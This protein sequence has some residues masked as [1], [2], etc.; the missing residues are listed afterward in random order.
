MWL[1]VSEV[2]GK[3]AFVMANI[4]LARRL[5]VVDFGLFTLAQ[6][7]TFFFWLAADLGISLYGIREIARAKENAEAVINPLFTL[8][9]SAGV[10]AFCCYIVAVFATV[11]TPHA[12][13]TFVAAGVYLIT[14]AFNIDWVFKGLEKFKWT[15]IGNAISSLVFLLGVVVIVQDAGDT[16]MASILWA[17][18]Y[19]GGAT[20]LL[21]S[22]HREGV[23]IRPVFN[24]R[25]WIG[26]LKESLHFTIS[27]V[28]SLAGAYLPIA[29][30]GYYSGTYEVGIYSAPYR[31]VATVV[32]AGFLIP[33]AFY[34]VLAESFRKNRPLFNEAQQRLKLIMLSLGIIASFGGTLFARQ[35]LDLIYGESYVASLAVFQIIVWWIFLSYIRVSLG[36]VL[37]A[38]GFH[39]RQNLGV[40]AGAIAIAAASMVLIPVG[41]ASGA[42]N[43]LVVGECFTVIVFLLQSWRVFGTPTITEMRGHAA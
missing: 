29:F 2:L 30:L 14:Y 36:S 38:A 4:I 15:A 5:G 18:S 39:R 41:G 31:L 22:I 25:V 34:P 40:F 12:R 10:V 8:R 24:Y 27:G 33:T 1:L 35:I 19:A 16:I 42:A 3:G 32:T 17:V 9:I 20:F 23:R 7:Q 11:S 37:L 21:L 43:A 6:T 28:L 26:H 13:A